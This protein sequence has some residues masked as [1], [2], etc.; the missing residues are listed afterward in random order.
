MIP[1]LNMNG[2]DLAIAAIFVF[3]M[4][5]GIWV[6]LLHQ[7]TVVISLYVGY[8]VAGQYHDRLF[9]FLRG[10]SDN[11]QLVFLLA[12]AIVFAGT[13]VVAM[14][15]GKG[16]TRVVQ[17]TIAGWFDKLLGALFGTVKAL[18]IVILLHM[19][20]TTFVAADTPLLQKSLLVPSLSQATVLFQQVIKDEKVR[21]AF[22]KKEPA[23]AKD[24][25]AS[26][27]SLAAPESTGQETISPSSPPSAPVEQRSDNNSG[28]EQGAS[29]ESGPSSVQPLPSPLPDNDQKR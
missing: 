7:I 23:I 4:A 1:G 5:R 25:E 11:P 17:L 14:L 15:A 19:L 12:Y 27:P 3:F 9:P 28:K 8:L 13:Y 29:K 10:V 16:L 20:I 2:Y 18:I 22:Q 21:Q 24:K 6:G 26:S